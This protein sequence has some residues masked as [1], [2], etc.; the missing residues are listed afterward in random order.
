MLALTRVWLP[1]GIGLAGLAGILIGHG[2]TSSPWAAAGVSL[3]LV[4]VIVWMIN[5][6]FRIGVQS[7]RER[8]REERARQYFEEHGRWPDD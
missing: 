7:N 3:M 8:E 4:A 2:S 1:L 5:W 6:M